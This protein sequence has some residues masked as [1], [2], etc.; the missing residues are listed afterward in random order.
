[1]PTTT[2]LHPGW[3]VQLAIH[4]AVRRDL[5]RLSGALEAGE[6][7]SAEAIRT[8]WADLA[9]ALHH[10]HELEDGVVWPRLAARLEGRADGLLARNAQQHASMSA[11]MDDCGAALATMTIDPSAARAALATATEQI[12]SHLADEEADILPLIPEAFT[13]EDVA[14]FLAESAKLDPPQVFLPWVLDDAEAG[15]V[16][17]FTGSM[18]APARALLDTSWL[19]SRRMR[20]DTPAL[21]G[22]V[23]VVGALDDAYARA[24]DL[25]GNLRSDQLGQPS[26]CADWDLRATL[27]HLLGTMRMFTLV[28][29]GEVAGEDGGDLVGGDAQAALRNGATLNL[30]TWRAPAAFEG[31]RTYPFGTFPARA[32][33]LINLSEVIV[34]TWDVATAVGR[35]VPIDPLAAEMLVEFYGAIPLDAYRKHGVFGAEVEVASHA[36]AAHRLL[37]LL[38]RRPA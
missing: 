18:P 29:Q 4:R 20:L 11:A 31:D 23:G 8:Y 14:F 1:M 38:G 7:S 3:S 21:T 33:A 13:P 15:D 17:F 35:H 24:I 27:N 37:A 5:A 22:R 34:H 25:L 16:E 32:A 26:R 19:P 10:H 30:A 36:P 2:E 28:N 6:P 12:L 9:T